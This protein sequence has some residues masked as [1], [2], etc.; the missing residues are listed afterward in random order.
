MYSSIG[1]GIASIWRSEG[2][3]GFYQGYGSICLRDVPFTML[4]LCALS[5]AP[6]LL[7]EPSRQALRS[8][9]KTAWRCVRR[10]IYDNL[11]EVLLRWLSPSA[12]AAGQ[13]GGAE[14]PAPQ[15]S[16]ARRMAAELV[17]GCVTGKPRLTPTAGCAPP[18][19]LMAEGAYVGVGAVCGWVTNPLD[20][21]KTRLMVPVRQA[22]P[23]FLPASPFGQQS[24]SLRAQ[25]CTQRSRN[26]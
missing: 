13:E 12:A 24:R 3:L 19:D 26:S 23:N 2:L 17:S 4:E 22:T 25:P 18:A 6:N 20:M 10:G 16:G 1:Q 21:V 11:K 7:P 15:A 8:C 14:A 5:L 9:A